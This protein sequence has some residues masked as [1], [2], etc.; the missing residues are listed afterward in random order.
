MENN[1]YMKRLNRILIPVFFS[2]LLFPSGLWAQTF[3]GNATVTRYETGTLEGVMETTGKIQTDQE[4]EVTYMAGM[5]E[6]VVGRYRVGASMDPR[7]IAIEISNSIPPSP[8]MNVRLYL[9][10]GSD[11]QPVIPG[12][13]KES[14]GKVNFV[15]DQ[16]VEIKMDPGN[17]ASVGE[18]V[19]LVYLTSTNL[20]LP[21]GDWEV[22][23][24]SGQT[25][26]ASEKNA[27]GKA[28]EG[29]LAVIRRERP[30]IAEELGDV[31]EIEDAP[32]DFRLGKD[33]YYGQNGS[34]QDYNA[35]MAHFIV[36]AEAGQAEC[37][38]FVGVMYGEG[39]GVS[40]DLYE[41][42]KWYKKSA[43]Q[44]NAVGQY[45]LGLMY[46]NGTGVMKDHAES[47]RLFRLS[48]DQGYDHAQHNLGIMYRNGWGVK[49]NYREAV[50]WLSRA[51]ENGLAVSQL[52]L[53]RMYESG[54]GVNIDVFLAG[55]WYR[56]AADQGSQEAMEALKKLEI[57]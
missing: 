24:V 53:G 54:M 39:Q 35:A 12:L 27:T 50:S 43:E 26:L 30:N 32:E 6:M 49:Q 11:E 41:A 20:E 34:K 52:E 17:T 45:N 15:S 5:T 36:C 33:A 55:Q 18:V 25:V 14:R 47:V 22:V 44:G 51:A 2:L 40:Q 13:E 9:S 19:S 21:V 31:W 7:F 16:Y 56:L 42:V 23:S 29:M 37:Q 28:R 8:G 4:V 38:N 1:L 46:A 10:Q 48:A 57:K 3:L